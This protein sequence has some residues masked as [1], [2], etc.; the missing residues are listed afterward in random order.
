LFLFL[1]LVLRRIFP[2]LPP[3]VLQQK[4]RREKLVRKA[5]AVFL[6]LLET[7]ELSPKKPKVEPVNDKEMEVRKKVVGIIVNKYIMAGDT[8]GCI[9]NL[10][11]W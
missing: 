11:L 9:N 5:F 10:I 2:S 8:S 4:T 1:E 6:V 3:L 7:K